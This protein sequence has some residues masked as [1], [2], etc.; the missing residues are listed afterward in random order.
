MIRRTTDPAFVNAICNSHAVRPFI[1]YRDAEEPMDFAPACS[2][3]SGVV[4]LTDGSAALGCFAQTG[5]REWQMHSFFGEACRGRDAIAAARAMLD[6]MLPRWADRVWGAT[7][8]ENRAALWF[9]RQIGG[10][11]CGFDE[12]EAEGRVQL[13]ERVH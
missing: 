13:F 7:P 10:Q 3:M 6:W 4:F 11:P 5:E 8:V 9:N 1:D 2:P 12:Y